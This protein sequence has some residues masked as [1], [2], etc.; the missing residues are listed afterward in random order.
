MLLFTTWRQNNNLFIRYSYHTTAIFTT[1]NGNLQ[2]TTVTFI[3]NLSSH[4]ADWIL[5]ST[6]C[7]LCLAFLYAQG[8][9]CKT[10]YIVICVLCTHCCFCVRILVDPFCSQAC[11]YWFTRNQFDEHVSEAFFYVDI[12]FFLLS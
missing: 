12:K 10:F 6:C 7:L 2:T 5:T 4:N 8:S 11:C 9:W 3:S 1:N